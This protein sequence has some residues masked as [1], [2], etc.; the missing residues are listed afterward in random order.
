MSYVQKDPAIRAV[1]LFV[2]EGKTLHEIAASE[3]AADAIT[4][5]QLP[6]MVFDG[7]DVGGT[8]HTAPSHENSIAHSNH[9][10]LQILTSKFSLSASLAVGNNVLKALAVEKQDYALGA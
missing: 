3:K 7:V 10:L 2:T 1:P 4:A 9:D 6:E 8:V 5:F